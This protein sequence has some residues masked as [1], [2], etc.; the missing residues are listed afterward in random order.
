MGLQDGKGEPRETVIQAISILFLSGFF[1]NR[2]RYYKI[3]HFKNED[4]PSIHLLYS[5]TDCPGQTGHAQTMNVSA[6]KVLGFELV[7]PH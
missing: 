1:K 3:F 6:V 4:H 5:L 2:R 7:P